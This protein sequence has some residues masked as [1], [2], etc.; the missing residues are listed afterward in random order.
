MAYT[1]NRIN[2]RAGQSVIGEM[3]DS[4]Q[5]REQVLRSLVSHQLMPQDRSLV[6]A[7]PR[8]GMVLII[9][10]PNINTGFCIVHV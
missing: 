7:L 10:G 4:G 2:Y 6:R 5:T 1:I 8:F 9:A 3:I